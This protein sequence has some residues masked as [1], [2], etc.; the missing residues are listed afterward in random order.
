M[1]IEPARI[2]VRNPPEQFAG[3]VW[4]DVIAAR[5]EP[6]QRMTVATVHFA[7]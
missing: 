3:A 4:V 1:N 7:P 2:K 5:H 6:D